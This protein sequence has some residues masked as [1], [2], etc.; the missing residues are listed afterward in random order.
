MLLSFVQ[1]TFAN[2]PD[3]QGETEQT[4]SQIMME[5]NSAKSQLQQL[6][7]LVRN[8]FLNLKF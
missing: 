2:I 7:D 4:Y 3:L 1:F 5:L 6:Y 8:G